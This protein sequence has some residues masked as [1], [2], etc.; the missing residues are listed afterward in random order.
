MVE[1]PGRSLTPPA[2]SRDLAVFLT[3]KTI[4]DIGFALDFICL[5]VFIW[6][7]TGSTLSPYAG[8]GSY[9]RIAAELR[10]KIERGT[11]IKY[12]NGLGQGSSQPAELPRSRIARD[13]AVIWVNRCG[14]SRPTPSRAV[15]VGPMVDPEDDDPWRFVVYLIDHPVRPAPCGP[16]PRQLAAQ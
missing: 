1:T 7:R 11:L 4:S 2:A 10:A 9:Q 15:D 14:G 5:S 6:V 3:A 8:P 12:A 16:E 13:C